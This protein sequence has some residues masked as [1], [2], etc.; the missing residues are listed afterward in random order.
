MMIFKRR[1][2][3]SIEDLISDD[4]FGNCLLWNSYIHN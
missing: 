4:D 3:L 1:C 2:Q